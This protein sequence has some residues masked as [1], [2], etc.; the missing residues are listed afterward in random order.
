M[1]RLMTGYRPHAVLLLLLSLLSLRAGLRHE[2]NEE[3]LVRASSG[4]LSS[5]IEA[6]HTLACRRD[7]PLNDRLIAEL[8]A[9]PEPVLRELV[10]LPVF[11]RAGTPAIRE[12]AIQG[13][14]ARVLRRRLR[15]LLQ[16]RFGSFDAMTLAELGE[17]LDAAA[18]PIQGD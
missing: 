18:P 12:A 8:L 11:T 16:E 1:E 14:E 2:S 13:E 5:R 10:M 17:F 6:L 7:T 15:F 3:L 4:E 9:S